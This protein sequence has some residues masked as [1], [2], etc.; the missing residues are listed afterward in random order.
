MT[1]IVIER[2]KVTE[3]MIFKAN[4][5]SDKDLAFFNQIKFPDET[6]ESFRESTAYYLKKFALYEQGKKFLGWNWCAFF[7]GSY[8]GNYRRIYSL[9]FIEILYMIFYFLINISKNNSAFDDSAS[10]VN[11]FVS[12]ISIGYRIIFGC[13]A[14]LFYVK[15]IIKKIQQGSLSYKPSVWMILSPIAILILIGLIGTFILD[16]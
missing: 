13:Y 2:D 15:K 12:A 8:W 7:M 16:S 11:L 1:N 5:W 10:S 14:N 4:N 6:S 3:E 9:F